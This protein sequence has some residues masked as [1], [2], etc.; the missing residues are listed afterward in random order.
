L[1]A[2]SAERIKFAE[3]K[4]VGL[5]EKQVAQT[6]NHLSIHLKTE[7]N[8]DHLCAEMATKL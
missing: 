7:E 8:Q 4:S 2:L 3:F 1:A 5:H 6:W